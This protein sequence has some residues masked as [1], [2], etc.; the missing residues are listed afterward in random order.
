[1]AYC[2]VAQFIKNYDNRR[3]RELLSDSGT[4]V[5]QSDL[6][7]NTTLAQLL[8]EASE[9]VQA[10]VSVR[11]KY[12]HAEL[13]AMSASATHGFL[14]RRLTADLAYGLLVARRGTPAADLARIAPQWTWAQG[15]LADLRLGEMVFPLESDESHPE[16]GLP[17]V[18]DMTTNTGTDTFCSISGRTNGRLFPGADSS[19]GRC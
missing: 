11:K 2:T 16:A 10:A 7:S 12:T 9:L 15:V 14:L 8:S 18:S 3:I 17:G 4:P 1:M 5:A 19:C 6:A 13:L